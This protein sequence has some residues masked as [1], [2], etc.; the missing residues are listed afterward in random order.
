MSYA[1]PDHFIRA[2]SEREAR[3]LTDEDNTGFINDEKLGTAL[4]RAS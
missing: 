4:E 2:F 1:T 3:A